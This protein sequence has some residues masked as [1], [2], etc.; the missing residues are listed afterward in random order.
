MP[1]R[2]VRV[3]DPD[4]QVSRALTLTYYADNPLEGGAIASGPVKEITDHAGRKLGFEYSETGYL[5]R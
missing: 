5:T 3:D 4:D 2:L 1:R